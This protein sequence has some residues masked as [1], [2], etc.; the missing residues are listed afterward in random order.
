MASAARWRHKAPWPF[1]WSSLNCY[2]KSIQRSGNQN[3]DFCLKLSWL[4]NRLFPNAKP[5]PVE[6][7]GVLGAET[8]VN[9]MPM[10]SRLP[11]VSGNVS[12]CRVG[13]KI[14]SERRHHKTK[15]EDCGRGFSGQCACF[16]LLC[17][18]SFRYYVSRGFGE[19]RRRRHYV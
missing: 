19:F 12:R 10:P 2:L 7:S 6:A 9:V 14:D 17:Y 1:T 18:I 8:T 4:R 15:G 11:K 5:Y 3:D 16:A 13:R